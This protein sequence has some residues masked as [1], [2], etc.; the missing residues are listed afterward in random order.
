MLPETFRLRRRT[1]CTAAAG[2]AGL[3]TLP[4]SAAGK[5]ERLKITKIDIYQVVV[6]VPDDIINSPEF[7]PDGLTEFPK[8]PKII[9]R[10]HTDSGLTGIGET[11]RSVPKQG[12]LENA[13]QL[14]GQNALDLNLPRLNLPNSATRPAFEI[15]LYDVIGKA[16]GWPVY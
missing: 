1:F 13:K 3:P 11:S 15:A 6:P 12:A 5:S 8:G 4:A 9:V 2:L 16:F 10:L 14:Q 7:G